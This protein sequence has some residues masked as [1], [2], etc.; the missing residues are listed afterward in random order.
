MKLGYVEAKDQKYQA[1]IDANIGDSKAVRGNC[2]PLAKQMASAFPELTVVRA[3]YHCLIPG[4]EHTWC[5]TSAN[6]IIDPSSHQWDEPY[7]YDRADPFH[8]EDF[9]NG[10]CPWCGVLLYPDTT[11][12]KRHFEEEELGPHEMCMRYFKE[13]LEACN[14][15]VPGVGDITIT[16]RD[17]IGNVV[18]YS[19][20]TQADLQRAH[21]DH[22]CGAG[23]GICYQESLD[24]YEEHVTVLVWPDN[25]WFRYVKGR[26]EDGMIQAIADNGRDYDAREMARGLSEEEIDNIVHD[27]K[28]DVLEEVLV[29]GDGTWFRC[30][31]DQ[32]AVALESAVSNGGLH[33]RVIEVTSTLTDEE[34][35]EVV[36]GKRPAV[37]TNQDGSGSFTGKLV[38][39]GL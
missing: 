26:N 37:V 21:D 10:K 14:E 12:N 23:C 13:D 16:V 36:Q 32:T 30:S 4:S 8:E 27:V 2:S 17:R 18:E 39:M 33:Y 28:P 38:G 29:W 22:K 25:N 6:E 5:I 20:I 34:V 15:D 3:S 35:G 1:W 7:E 31:P 9:S 24:Y 19:L 11:R